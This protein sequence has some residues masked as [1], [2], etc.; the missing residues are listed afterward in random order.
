[1]AKDFA[2]KPTCKGRSR[3]RTW[4]VFRLSLVLVSVVPTLALAAARDPVR[5]G[6]EGAYPPFSEVGPDGELKGFEIDIARALCAQM[7][8]RCV[9]VQQNFDGMI[10]AL[11]ANKIDA[12]IASLSITEERRKSV[13][14]SD[15]YYKTPGRLVARRDAAL[16][17]IPQGLTGKRIGVQRSSTYDRYATD[18]FVRS[19]IVRYA[20][21]DD[22]F[23]DLASGRIDAVLADSVATHVG[24]LGQPGGQAYAFV[25]PDFVDPRYFGNG[26]GVAVRKGDDGLREAFNEAI[27]AIRANGTYAAIQSRYVD[28]DLYVDS[29]PARVASRS[30]LHGY[31][32]SLL[33]GALMTLSLAMLSLLLALVLALL[34]ATAKLSRSAWLRGMAHAYTTGVRSVPDLVL[35]LLVFFG[36]QALVNTAALRLGFAQGP[37]LDPFVAGVLT[38]GVIYGAYLTETF[39]GAFLSV[40]VGQLEAAQAFGMSRWLAFRRIVG[41]QMLRHALPPLLNNWLVLLKSTAIVSVIGLTDLMQRASLAAGA[42]HEPFLFYGVVG[43]LYLGFTACSEVAFSWLSRRLDVGAR[44]AVY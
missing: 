38:I 28:F 43:L 33:Q 21:M 14:F 23:L 27:T 4:L 35:M 2:V 24:F 44:R 13:D 6:V 20:K 1:V 32:L 16:L 9:L 34:G 37:D 11:N 17:P 18:N 31:A 29:A 39:R 15:K 41:P 30:L 7:R 40:P 42:T 36:G 5:I 12:V 22:V 3:Q 10:P 19:E 8:A 26:V 25:G